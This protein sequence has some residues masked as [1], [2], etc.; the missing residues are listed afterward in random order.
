MIGLAQHSQDMFSRISLD[1]ATAFLFNNDVRSLSAGLIYPPGTAEAANHDI[2]QPSNRFAHAFSDCQRQVAFRTFLG[3]IWPLTEMT[4]EATKA[5]MEIVNGF[6][7]PLIA[8]ALHN[9]KLA[10]ESREKSGGKE[11]EHRSLLD[12][13]VTESDGGSIV[14]HFFSSAHFGIRRLQR[15]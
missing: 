1:S 5:N 2:S 9:K 14:W 3:A 11:E 15:H 4:G 6:I 7:D 10:A 13:L 12:L 8:E